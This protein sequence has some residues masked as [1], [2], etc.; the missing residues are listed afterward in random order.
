MSL[1][2]HT[3]REEMNLRAKTQ[4][5]FWCCLKQKSRPFYD[6]LQVDLPLAPAPPH[7]TAICCRMEGGKVSLSSFP[8]TRPATPTTEPTFHSALLSTLF[9][10]ARLL[11]YWP[12]L[13]FVSAISFFLSFFL[14]LLRK[15]CPE[16]TSAANLPLFVCEPPPQHGHSWTSGVGPCL[17]TKPRLS[18]QSTLNLT[19]RPGL[20]SL[21]LY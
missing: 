11:S 3:G 16:V 18:K 2:A 10:S 1:Y 8:L 5:S 14:L 9:C 13:L 19:T 17:G 21:K 12:N 20:L 7:F 4:V 15:I 6:K